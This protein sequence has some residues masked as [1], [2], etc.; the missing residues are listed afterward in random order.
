MPKRTR[1]AGR[2]PKQSVR[3]ASTRYASLAFDAKRRLIGASRNARK[4]LG[5]GAK[6]LSPGTSYQALR[7]ALPEALRRGLPAELDDKIRAARHGDVASFSI[8]ISPLGFQVTLL[9]EPDAWA[10]VDEARRRIRVTV[11]ESSRDAVAIFDPDDRLVAFNRKMSELLKP[12]ADLLKIGAY[13]GDI[14]HGQAMRGFYRKGGR[15]VDEYLT[16]H[17]VQST[18]PLRSLY[19]Y[20]DGRWIEAIDRRTEDGFTVLVRADVTERVEREREQAEQNMLLELALANMSNGIT[21][22]DSDKRL[23]LWNDR[24]AELFDIPRVAL[25]QGM[26]FQEVYRL[27]IGEEAANALSSEQRAS[28]AATSQSREKLV[29]RRTTK[30]GRL[31]EGRHTPI[32]TGGGV[33]TFIDITE[34]EAARRNLETALSDARRADALKSIFLANVTHEL[35]TPLNA[36][37]G[38]ADLLAS[39][40]YGALNPKQREFVDSISSSGT[41]LLSL[42]DGIIDLTRVE[43]QQIKLDIGPVDLAHLV[44]TSIRMIEAARRGRPTPR[45]VNALGSDPPAIYADD[46]KLKQIL[47]NLIGNAAKFTPP[48][49]EVVIRARAGED[50]ACIIEISD[51]GPGIAPED[52]PRV[53]EPFY[54]SQSPATRAIE[55]SGLGLSLAKALAELHGGRLEIKSTVG[56]GTVLTVHLPAT[57]RPASGDPGTGM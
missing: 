34:I 53:F 4:L 27:N 2:A 15:D 31:I 1:G 46:G 16:A 5:L 56:R 42:I 20:D 11:L 14:I 25:R 24:Y 30:T 21:Y 17:A 29:F 51:T 12:H 37:T 28:A 44:D 45:I 33:A 55:G 38:F 49:G 43:T 47:I 48:E 54:R 40:H 41:H 22:Y 8:P 18:E 35:R 19:T 23:Q 7:R 6:T 10:A 39:E 36:V 32:A 57:P 26:E 52:L 3:T 9:F 13:L 50:E